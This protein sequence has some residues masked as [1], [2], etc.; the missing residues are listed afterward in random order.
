MALETIL[1][2]FFRKVF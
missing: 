2:K 1:E